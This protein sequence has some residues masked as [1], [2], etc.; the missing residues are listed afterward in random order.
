MNYSNQKKK[1]NRIKPTKISQKVL[2]STVNKISVDYVLKRE[3]LEN[4]NKKQVNIML[5]HK[6]LKTNEIKFLELKK[7]NC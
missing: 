2:L 3:S 1:W 5:I 7:S 4:T 6:I